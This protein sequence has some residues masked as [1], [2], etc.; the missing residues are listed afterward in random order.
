MK[1]CQ[2][3]TCTISINVDHSTFRTEAVRLTHNGLREL[4]YAA[5]LAVAVWAWAHQT[6]R[7]SSRNTVRKL[8]VQSRLEHWCRVPTLFRIMFAWTRHIRTR[9]SWNAIHLSRK[10]FLYI[11]GI[12]Y[13]YLISRKWCT[14]YWTICEFQIRLKYVGH[15]DA[16]THGCLV[17]IDTYH[18]QRLLRLQS[19]HPSHR[20]RE[21]GHAAVIVVSWYGRKTHH[22][23][24]QFS[25]RHHARS[26]GKWM[27]AMVDNVRMNQWRGP[28]NTARII[29]NIYLVRSIYI[30]ENNGGSNILEYIYI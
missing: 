28:W 19:V 14:R 3:K 25:E 23:H 2:P 17:R 10:L 1:G 7:D 29:K 22:G 11:P 26:P 27:K 24:A 13:F 6:P 30:R 9:C 8:T 20:L 21:L 18:R 4:G 15:V 16:G 12:L 5:M